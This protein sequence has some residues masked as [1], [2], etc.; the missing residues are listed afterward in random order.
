MATAQIYTPCDRLPLATA[1]HAWA[2]LPRLGAAC[3]NAG[4]LS[5]GAHPYGI[6][7]TFGRSETSVI[8]ETSAQ[9]RQPHAGCYLAMRRKKQRNRCASRQLQDKVGGVAPDRPLLEVEWRVV[10]PE[11]EWCPLPRLAAESTP[12]KTFPICIRFGKAA[13]PCPDPK[14]RVRPTLG[15][16]RAWPILFASCRPTIKTST[17]GVGS[18]DRAAKTAAIS[19]RSPR[20]GRSTRLLVARS[21][22][23]AHRACKLSM[24]SAA[25]QHTRRSWDL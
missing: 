15:I 1:A 18:G 10:A 4:G 8:L 24:R 25:R 11:I 6:K 23:G 16:N 3:G 2:F 21:P 5:P 17:A 7:P 13:R 19:A 9:W 20:T 12:I 22:R 14:L